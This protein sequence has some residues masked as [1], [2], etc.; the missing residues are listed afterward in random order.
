MNYYRTIER[1]ERICLTYSSI[2]LSSKSGHGIP[3]F[4]IS[5]FLDM[6]SSRRIALHNFIFSTPLKTRWRRCSELPTYEGGELLLKK[7]HCHLRIVGILL[8]TFFSIHFSVFK[9]LHRFFLQSFEIRK[10]KLKNQ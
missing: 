7:R 1:K 8:F 9:I 3:D 6:I 5:F 4:W 2:Q 10:M